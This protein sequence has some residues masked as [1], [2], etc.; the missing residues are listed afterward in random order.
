M[1][2]LHSEVNII[3]Y[4]SARSKYLTF[5]FYINVCVLD[6]LNILKGT[7]KEIVDGMEEAGTAVA[8]SVKKAGTAVADEYHKVEHA[9]EDGYHKVEHAVEDEYKVV[10]KTYQEACACSNYNCGCCAH[11][12]EPHIDLNA[13]SKSTL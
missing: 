8:R 5:S 3:I 11:L 1:K 13:T 12:E 7:W 9:V 4:Y 10:K 2:I 6:F